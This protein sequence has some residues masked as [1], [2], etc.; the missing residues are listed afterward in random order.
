MFK[1]GDALASGVCFVLWSWHFI[2]RC[3]FVF[4]T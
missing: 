1:S 2:Y 3:N 4:I